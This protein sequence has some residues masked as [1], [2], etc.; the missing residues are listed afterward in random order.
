MN[1][2]A[3]SAGRP[4]LSFPAHQERSF[5]PLG[6][7]KAETSRFLLLGLDAKRV[8]RFDNERSEFLSEVSARR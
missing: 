8:G 7:D 3:S 4:N 5:H 6:S 2:D 1:Q